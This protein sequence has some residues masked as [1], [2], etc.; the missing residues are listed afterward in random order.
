MNFAIVTFPLESM[1]KWGLS[2]FRVGERGVAS[3]PG[4]IG[5]S[6]KTDAPLRGAPEGSRATHFVA[7]PTFSCSRALRALKR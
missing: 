7:A 1:K 3:G 5:R 6:S 4:T 2:G